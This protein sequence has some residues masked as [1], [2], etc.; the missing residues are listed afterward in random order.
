MA[1]SVDGHTIT[2]A[3]AKSS[4]GEY[5]KVVLASPRLLVVWVCSSCLQGCYVLDLNLPRRWTLWVG[6]SLQVWWGQGLRNI[7]LKQGSAARSFILVSVQ[8][9]PVSDDEKIKPGNLI[10]AQLFLLV[11]FP[12]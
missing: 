6:K 3:A 11:W 2:C 4:P 10:S 1:P 12:L 5:K 7:R 9:I 8:G